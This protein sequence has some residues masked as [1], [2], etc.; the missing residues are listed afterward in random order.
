MKECNRVHSAND[1]PKLWSGGKN[2][3]MYYLFCRKL[4]CLADE[5]PVYVICS[6][7]AYHILGESRDVY[8]GS[9]RVLPHQTSQFWR[10]NHIKFNDAMRGVAH[11]VGH[12]L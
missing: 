3:D 12:G 5:G 4:Y 11:V 6:V 8:C 10:L 2:H 1:A 9:V 7:L